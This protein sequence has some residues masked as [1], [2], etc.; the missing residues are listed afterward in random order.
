[1]G[2]IG[3]GLNGAKTRMKLEGEKDPLAHAIEQQRAD[4]LALQRRIQKLKPRTSHP[5]KI[6]E[7]IRYQAWPPPANPP[8]SP[9]PV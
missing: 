4:I 2:V 9:Y 6:I 1:M 8:G 7:E 5:E 3:S